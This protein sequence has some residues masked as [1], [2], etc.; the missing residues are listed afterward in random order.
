MNALDLIPGLR[1]HLDAR[2]KSAFGDG[3]TGP[4]A[5]SEASIE[6]QIAILGLGGRRRT[7]ALQVVAFHRSVS[8]L[9]STIAELI[10]QTV[11]VVDRK[12]RTINPQPEPLLDLLTSTPDGVTSAYNFWED[13]LL[14]ML[15]EGNALIAI[16]RQPDGRVIRL[17]RMIA[18]DAKIEEKN[19]R[20]IYT[21]PLAGASAPQGNRSF[22]LRNVIHAR[23][24]DYKGDDTLLKTERSGFTR[25]TS[26]FIRPDIRITGEI[27]RWLLRYFDGK[28]GAIKSDL[29]IAFEGKQ[30]PDAQAALLDAIK[31]YMQKRLPIAI[32]NSPK[33]TPLNQTPQN[34]DTSALRSQQVTSIARAFGIP[35]PLI[36]E[37]VTQWGSG[38]SE[39]ARLYWKFGARQHLTRL[40]QSASIRLLKQKSHHFAVN[41]MEIF[42][43]DLEGLT[44]LINATKGDQ[45]RPIVG[46]EEIRRWIGQDDDPPESVTGYAPPSKGGEAAAGTDAAGGSGGADTARDRKRKRKQKKSVDNG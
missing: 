5:F 42:R 41:E 6:D 18:K 20:L 26:D 22:T 37:N 33:F 38:I 27:S 19:G 46:P 32:W 34:A 4:S 8:L 45:Q 35:A 29:A 21:G 30:P 43:G 17:W 24:P 28:G 16:D 40:L 31:G 15:L 12:R 39:L 1:Q 44:D 10:S 36:G 7:E 13:T 2:P 14:D 11:H 25:P 9:S 3:A 23:A